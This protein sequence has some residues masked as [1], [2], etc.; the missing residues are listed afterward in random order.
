MGYRST[1]AYTIRFTDDDDRLNTQSFYTF[2]AEAKAN[3]ATRSALEEC[4]IDENKLQINYH[5]EDVK[6]YD[7]DPRVQNHEELLLLASDTI[8]TYEDTREC[9]GYVFARI[10]DNDDDNEWKAQ[11]KYSTDW[12]WLK[13]QLIKDW[14]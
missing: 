14:T 11:G 13:R 2:I 3:D 8:E 12:L 10:G 6:W 5:A 4:E 1:V 9:I 7:S